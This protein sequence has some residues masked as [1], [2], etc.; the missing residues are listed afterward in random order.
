MGQRHKALL[1]PTTIIVLIVA[2]LAILGWLAARGFSGTT[3]TKQHLPRIDWLPIEAS[4]I[5]FARND[6]GIF[7]WLSFECSLP[8]AA[9]ATFAEQKGWKPTWKTN[10]ST[11]LRATLKLPPLRF[12]E[13][14]AVDFYPVTLV[15]EVRKGNGGG[16]TVIYDPESRRLFVSQ[17]SN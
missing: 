9:F 13:G 12:V 4:D 15:H 2:A 14:R 11:G 17:S 5:S 16:I 7:P 3:E 10:Y 6:G 1:I 8:N